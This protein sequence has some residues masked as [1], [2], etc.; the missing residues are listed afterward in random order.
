VLCVR[1]ALRVVFA[2]RSDMK[3]GVE[4]VGRLTESVI[5]GLSIEE[6]R[7]IK[8]ETSLIIGNRGVAETFPYGYFKAWTLDT[9]TGRFDKI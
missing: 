7:A 6:R 3:A 2:Y 5:G 9:N 4:L 8:G 1:A